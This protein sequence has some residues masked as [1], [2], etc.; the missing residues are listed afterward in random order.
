MK[1]GDKIKELRKQHRMTQADLAKKL[2]VAPTAVSAWEGNHN[3]PLMDKITILADLFK[4]PITYFFDVEDLG[5]TGESVLLPIY[6]NISC[7]TG[8]VV[9]EQTGVYETTPKDWLNGGEYFYL[10]AKG[11]SMIGAR[12]QE[13][14]LLLIRK[15]EDVE[16]GEIAA[17]VIEEEALLKRVYKTDNS[18]I[19]QSENPKYAP[20][21]YN[22]EQN[23]LIRIVGKLKKVVLNF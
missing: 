8:T 17:V 12:I 1:V 21:I 16:N 13:D 9:Y 10:R 3:R 20:I 18:I 6:G 11:D 22:P 4:V 15:Q 14:D 5:E 2:N 7:G 23:K 19:L